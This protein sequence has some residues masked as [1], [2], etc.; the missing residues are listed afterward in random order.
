MK[1]KE[2]I[3]LTIEQWVQLRKTEKSFNVPVWFKVTGNSMFPFI[4]AFMDDVM[5]IPFSADGYKVG[6]IVLFPAKRQGGDYCLHRI[7]KMEGEQV[8]T[9]GDGCKYPDDWI[10]KEKILGKAVIIQRGKIKIDCESP[11]W[12]KR[13]RRWNFFWRVRPVML[14]PFRVLNKISK[15]IKK[16]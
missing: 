12:V 10:P 5:I 7:W 11:K 9:L 2:C 4:R 15:I 6:D 8:Q 1:N 14:L 16:I 13:F 3:T